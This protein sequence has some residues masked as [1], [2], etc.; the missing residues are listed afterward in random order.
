VPEDVHQPQ[1]VLGGRVAGAELRAVT[2]GACDV[3]HTGLLVADDRHVGASG[4]LHGRLDLVGGD[5]ERRV[6]EEVVDLGVGEAGVARCQV[7][8]G[9]ELVVRVGGLAAECLV[10]EDLRQGRVAVLARRED[11]GT[12]TAAVVVRGHRRLC[13]GCIGGG[14]LG[15]R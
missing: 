5:P 2:G 11:V 12:L 9:R 8:V 1:S 15:K 7:V 4:G 10:E 14:R 6:L 3:R 13:T